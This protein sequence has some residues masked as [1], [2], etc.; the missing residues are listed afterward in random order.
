MP[1]Q[2]QPNVQNAAPSSGGGKADAFRNIGQIMGAFANGGSTSD[3]F[4]AGRSAGDYASKS[5]R[6]AEAADLGREAGTYAEASMAPDP[7]PGQL[8]P[9][10][11]VEANQEYLNNQIFSPGSPLGMG[12]NPAEAAMVLWDMNGNGS[13]MPALLQD[14]FGPA[15]MDQTIKPFS[16]EANYMSLPG[17]YRWKGGN[18]A[19]GAGQAAR[20]F[21]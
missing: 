2:L 1:R 3:L 14:M 4:S 17:Y 10:Q 11:T 20:G 15:P 6:G 18:A 12:L 7:G 21:R 5:N 9:E 13:Q 19:Q 16:P 8:A